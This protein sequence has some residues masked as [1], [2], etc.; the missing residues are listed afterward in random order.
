MKTLI[1]HNGSFHTD[2]VFACATLFLALKEKELKVIRTRD[3]EIIKT[4]DIVFDV[5]FVYDESKSRFDHHQGGAPKREN[6]IPYASFGLVWKKFGKEICTD[7]E[8]QIIDRGV[9]SFVDAVDNGLNLFESKTEVSNYSIASAIS[10]FNRTNFE[11]DNND[12]NF[13]VAVDFAKQIILR[14]VAS[15][16]S[17]LVQK[18]KI[19][20]AYALSENKKILMIDECVDKFAIH[21]TLQKYPETL[22]AVTKYEGDTWRLLCVRKQPQNF[23][24]RKSLPEAWAGKEGKELQEATGVQ[25]AIFCHK[26]RFFANTKTKDGAIALAM[27][28][29]ES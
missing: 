14:E 19:E 25:D 13:L 18:D 20:K 2:D 24:S 27:L 9:V 12:Q 6:G 26:G 23:E 29:L 8:A 7:D 15:A 10:S 22:F 16:K 4:G 17:Y 28:A 21:D 11:E 3:Q 5:G 1:T